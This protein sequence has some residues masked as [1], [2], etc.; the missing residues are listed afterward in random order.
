M[1]QCMRDT[2]GNKK[3]TKYII[4]RRNTFI[5]ISKELR[6]ENV[7]NETGPAKLRRIK[8]PLDQF[9]S[10]TCQQ[11][12]FEL[13]HCWLLRK[14]NVWFCELFF[15]F[16]YIIA[17]A[18]SVLKIKHSYGILMMTCTIYIII[19]IPLSLPTLSLSLSFRSKHTKLN[20]NFAINAGCW[21]YLFITWQTSHQTNKMSS[22]CHK[23]L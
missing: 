15:F 3:W 16:Q 14:S 19:I 9:L 6:S 2:N 17:G 21:Y 7:W 5:Y 4:D 8:L 11:H 23:A 10:L 20:I 12:Q 13:S 1:R 22:S 18:L